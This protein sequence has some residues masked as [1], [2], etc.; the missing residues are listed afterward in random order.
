MKARMNAQKFSAALYAVLAAFTTPPK[1]S[2][3]DLDDMTDRGCVAGNMLGA[4]VREINDES[5]TTSDPD[6]PFPGIFV[7]FKD[8]SGVSVNVEYIPKVA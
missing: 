1:M 8:G 6:R 3:D 5:M 7:A 2:Q 4:A